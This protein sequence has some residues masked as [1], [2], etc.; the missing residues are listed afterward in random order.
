MALSL[1]G[2]SHIMIHAWLHFNL[3]VRCCVLDS[4]AVKANHLFLVANGLDAATVEFL[5]S[6]RDLDTDCW[7]WWQF[8]LVEAGECG[9]EETTLI[10]H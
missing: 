8:W 7:H 10:F 4:L 9:A 2:E 6:A 3:F 5:E 1:E